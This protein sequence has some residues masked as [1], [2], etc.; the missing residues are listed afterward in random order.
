MLVNF[1]AMRW[2]RATFAQSKA[3]YH[4]EFVQDLAELLMGQTEITTEETF[5]SKLPEFLEDEP[6]A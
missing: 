6:R 1:A 4:P 2:I 5:V 3:K